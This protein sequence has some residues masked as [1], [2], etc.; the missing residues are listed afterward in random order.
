MAERDTSLRAWIK[1]VG[2][3]LVLPVYWALDV[4]QP[5]DRSRMFRLPIDALDFTHQT[6]L[7][8]TRIGH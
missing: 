8:N 6:P 7:R 1:G 2:P 4:G 5:G 3:L